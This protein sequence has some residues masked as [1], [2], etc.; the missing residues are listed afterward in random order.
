MS[1]QKRS[2][3]DIAQLIALDIPEGSY[4]NLGIGLPT[5]VAKY[6]PQDKEI[7]L[8][9]E[10]GV[11]A[12]GPPPKAGEEDQDLVN[13][14]KELVTLLDGGCFMHHGDSFDIMRGGHLDICV[15]GAFQV[16]VNGDLAN[17]H[18]GK[19]DD[20]PA[21]GGAMDLAVG[22]KSI[23]VYMEHVTKHGEAK[24]VNTLSYPMT[25]EQCVNRIYTDLCIIELK[26]HKAY[27]T[28]VVQGLSFDE[29]QALTGCPLIDARVN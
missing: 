29:L 23:Y 10:N 22:A 17:W 28:E 27:V 11:L 19:V 3:E 24:I 25:G 2:R 18:T 21:V 12:F 7:F 9:S 13:A 15:I 5:N 16:A 6:L 4:V 1:I 20:V 14:G 26:D 8:H